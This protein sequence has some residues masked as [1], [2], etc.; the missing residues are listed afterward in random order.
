MTR[1]RSELVS[2]SET[3]WY[4]VV[5]RCVR[6][7]FLCGED[8]HTGKNFDHRRGWIEARIRQL[9]SVFAIDV[10]A[11]AVM[12]NHYH[13]VLKVDAQRARELSDEEALR[14]W[15]QL[16]SGPLLVQR[17]LDARETLGE[18]E[19]QRV[20]QWAEEYRSRLADL[21]W[22]MRVLNEGIARRANKEDQVKGRF[23]EG[24][25]K[26][27]ALLDEQA[28]LSAMAYVDLNPIRAALAETPEESDYTSVQARLLPQVAHAR[29]AEAIVAME[30]DVS[31]ADVAESQAGGDG[32][33]DGLAVDA[34][35][36]A[37]VADSEDAGALRMACAASA[38]PASDEK[39]QARLA[40][41]PL[42]PFDATG[43]EGW[44]IPYAFEDYVDLVETLG[45]CVHPHKRGFMPEKTPKL[46]DRLGIDTAA[47][48]EHGTKFL[49]EFGCAV[50]KPAALI[51]LAAHRQAKFLRG[52]RTAARLFEQKAA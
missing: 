44:A 51:E 18:A 9:A 4:H 42:L 50:G 43:R 22:Y 27:Q 38:A 35:M 10:A 3:P 14:R 1:P 25:F 17:Y 21:S 34:D 49:K 19:V 47:F 7:A 5:S 36:P 30:A 24:R 11:Y 8:A 29:M 6:R 23:W 37:T 46:L 13:I 48:I 41:A 16:F 28:V 40:P 52:M 39:S 12:S 32:G 15:T 31:V 45:C 20:R 2:L 33:R 26:S